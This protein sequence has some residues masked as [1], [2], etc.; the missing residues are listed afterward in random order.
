MWSHRITAPVKK[1]IAS[2][3]ENQL[4]VIEDRFFSPSNPNELR[5]PAYLIKTREFDL[6]ETVMKEKT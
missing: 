3:T 6:N 1:A 5:T 2:N 4:T